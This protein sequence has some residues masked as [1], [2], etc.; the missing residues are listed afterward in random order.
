VPFLG[1]IHGHPSPRAAVA[2]G[3]APIAAAGR[4]RVIRVR[5]KVKIFTRRAHISPVEDD[6]K[7]ALR[8][9]RTLLN[10]QKGVLDA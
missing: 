5:T 1:M 6:N 4:R 10:S 3:P 8:P 9:A 7:G 2:A